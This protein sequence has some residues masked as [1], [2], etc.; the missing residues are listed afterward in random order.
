MAGERSRYG[1]MFSALGAIV[2]AVSVFLPWYGLSFTANGIAVV[3]QVGDQVASQ[4]G[5]ATLQSYT[6][7]LHANLG[8]LAGQEFTALSA[9]QVLKDLNV[10]LLVLAGLA[11]LDAL[12]PLARPE[13]RLPEGAGASVVLVGSVATVCVLYRILVP[14]T[15]AGDLVALSVREGAWLALVGSLTM[16]LAGLW[17]LFFRTRAGGG[18]ARVTSAWSGLSG[19][20]PEP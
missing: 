12:V 5:N 4:F 17:P 2:L 13:A 14:P 18:E 3:Q 20:T 10:I 19:W 1:L 7:G 6:S 15:P 16:V 11:L 8:G 9:H